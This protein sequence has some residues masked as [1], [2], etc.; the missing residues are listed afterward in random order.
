M[1]DPKWASTDTTQA[2][3][4]TENAPAMRFF[5]MNAIISEFGEQMH[6]LQ[7]TT[8]KGEII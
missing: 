8:E 6:R 1:H 2:A 7:K 3:S 4:K 5:E